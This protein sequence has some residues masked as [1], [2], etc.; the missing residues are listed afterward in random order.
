MTEKTNIYFSA[1]VSKT[2]GAG[3]AIL[4]EN[5]D[6]NGNIVH[7]LIDTGT[8]VYEEVIT[9]FLKKHNVKK[10]DFLCITHQHSDHIGNALSVIQNYEIDTLIMKEFDQ[11]WG[12]NGNQK[13]YEDVII[14]AMQKK[15]KKILG[16]S[17]LSLISDEYSPSRS[18]N[19]KKY[20]KGAKEENFE[21]FNENNVKFKFGTSIIEVMNWEIFDSEG[22]LFIIGKNADKLGKKLYRQIISDDNEQSLGILFTQGKRKAFFSGDMNNNKKNVGGV[23]IGDEDRLKNKIGK[24]DLLKLGHH[25]LRGSNTLGY[26]KILNPQYVIITNERGLIDYEM[27]EYLI[28]NKISYLYSTYDEYEVS[29]TI[30]DEE[31]VFGFGTPGVKRLK[32]KIIYIPKEKIYQNYLKCGMNVKY[33][34]MEEKAKNWND[35]KYIIENHEIKEEIDNNN[36]Y[37]IMNILKIYLELTEGNEFYIANSCIKLRPYDKIILI[38]KTNEIIIKRDKSLNNYPLFDV[39]NSSLILGEENMSGKIIIDGN[40]E[41]VI[42]NSHLINLFNSD[43][44]IYENVCLCNNLNRS[45]TKSIDSKIL[46]NNIYYGS[47]IFGFFSIINMYGG[48]ISNNI[49]E[50]FID[51]ENSDGILPEIINGYQFFLSRGAG[52]FIH[53]S[54]VNIYNGKICNNKAI[55]NSKVYTNKNSSNYNIYSPHINCEGIGIFADFMSELNLYKG[56][57]SNNTGINNANINLITPNDNKTTKIQAISNYIFGSAIYMRYSKFKMF[58]DF[59]IEKKTGEINS[60]LNVEKNCS[61]NLGDFCSARGIQLYFNMSNVVIQGGLIQNGKIIS[62]ITENVFDIN[63]LGTNK[64][65]NS[66]CLG[67]AIF[68]NECNNIEISNLEIFDCFADQ[69]GAIYIKN[70]SGKISYCN[71]Q[72]NEANNHGGSIFINDIKNSEFQLLNCKIVKNL[73]KSGSGG[74]IFV[75]SNLIIDGEMTIISDN[76]AQGAGGG[77]FVAGKLILK[78]GKISHNKALNGSGGGISVS[79]SLQIINGDISH[80]WSNLNGGGINYNNAKEFICDK[81]KINIIVHDNSS[82]GTL[83]DI[84]PLK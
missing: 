66:E 62:K 40:K 42:S 54:I 65:I 71:F 6:N 56:E 69:G 34:I 36:N 57:I 28:Q 70:G 55:N 2:I 73:T 33:N 4:L 26:L 31:I 60:I 45:T 32:D 15:V 13:R 64:K 72:R 9:N 67:G 68:F 38:S 46:K 83:K 18:P 61:I 5:I 53:S 74:G 30:S 39:E 75:S 51:E 81:D 8:K 17:Y 43:F 21:S 82:N 23:L 27:N 63:D 80:N 76:N 20:I 19:F 37:Y 41:K 25:G 14:L 24:I 11:K 35:L 16:I 10:L 1:E 58:K 22:N 59:I 49:H 50:I 84:S 48:E 77:I 79:G 3:D 78:N 44:S 52:I 29:A 47:G 12:V 7:A